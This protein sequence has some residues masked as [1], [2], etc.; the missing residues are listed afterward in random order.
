MPNPLVRPRTHA[1]AHQSGRCYY[2]GMPMWADNPLEFANAHGITLGQ[3][4]RLQCTGEHLVARQDGGS[5]ARSNIVAA[6]LF[7]NKGRHSRKTPLPPDRYLQLVRKRMK[8]GRWHGPWL[9]QK[10]LLPKS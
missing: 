10:G 1:F 9:H 3:A 2:C 4:K 7:C 6:C 8:V 5:T